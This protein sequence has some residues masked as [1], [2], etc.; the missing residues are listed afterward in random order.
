MSGFDFHPDLFEHRNDAMDA[1]AA[2]GLEW[3]TDFSSVD[4]VHD[5]Y[6][7]EV[8]GIPTREGAQQVQAVLKGVFS[9]W[10]HSHVYLKEW[11]S[12]EAGWKV[13][14]HRQGRRQGGQFAG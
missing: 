11:G 6:G 9:D 13:V 3:M 1:L 14:M 12:R 10:P 4:V 5:L 2:A 7:L 8:C